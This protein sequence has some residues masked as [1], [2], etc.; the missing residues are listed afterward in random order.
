M[1]PP[2]LLP[3]LLPHLRTELR[4]RRDFGVQDEQRFRQRLPHSTQNIAPAGFSV[5]HFAQSIPLCPKFVEQRLGVLQIGGV[6][7][8]G[9]PAVDFG[10]HRARFVATT[11][12]ASSR[13]RLIVAR[14]SHALRAHL[15]RERDSF[16]EVGL[17]QFCLPLFEPQF[18]A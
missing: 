6:E 2:R 5:L 13:A 18:A 3:E 1:K 9:E 16:A 7:A 12:V 17:G 4:A 11:L 10:E 14:S 15:L 8:L